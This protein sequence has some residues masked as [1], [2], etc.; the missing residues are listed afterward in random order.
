MKAYSGG[1]S[2]NALRTCRKRFSTQL[3]AP[4]VFSAQRTLPGELSHT[5]VLALAHCDVPSSFDPER[6][7]R[8][9]SEPDFLARFS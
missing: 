1:R 3:L 7:L 9:V 6:Q 8:V 4:L 2:A 5:L